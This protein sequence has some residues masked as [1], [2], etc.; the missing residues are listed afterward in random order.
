ML[1]FTESFPQKF[2]LH[3]YP[4]RLSKS[5]EASYIVKRF[6]EAP[7]N[8]KLATYFP[9]SLEN[10]IS[11]RILQ[12]QPFYPVSITELRSIEG[13]SELQTFQVLETFN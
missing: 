12:N 1:A 5:R 10:C 7:V 6:T 8:L 9:I 11:N 4:K 3:R 2:W 13:I